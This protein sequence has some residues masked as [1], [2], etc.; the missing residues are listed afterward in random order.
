MIKREV[1]QAAR[2]LMDDGFQVS[3]LGDRILVSLENRPIT[4]LKVKIALSDFQVKNIYKIDNEVEVFL[5]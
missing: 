2:K 3:N 1:I 4:T 5:K